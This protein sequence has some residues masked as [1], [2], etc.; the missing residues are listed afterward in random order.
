VKKAKDLREGG[1][2][3]RSDGAFKV[4]R[5]KDFHFTEMDLE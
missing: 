4:L 2:G 3:G 1:G 5:H